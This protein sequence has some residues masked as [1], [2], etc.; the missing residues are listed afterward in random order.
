MQ[1]L[2]AGEVESVLEAYHSGVSSLPAE[3]RPWAA[4]NVTEPDPSDLARRLDDGFVGAC[5]PADALSGPAGFDRL[6]GVLE[7]LE[8]REL[9]LFIHPGPPALP[10]VPGAPSWWSAM[11]S[12]VASMQAAWYAMAVWGRSAHPRLRVC[13]A[14]LA[15]LAPLHRERLAARGGYPATADP[16]LFLDTSSYGTRAVDAVARELG[17]ERLVHGSDRPVVAATEPELGDAVRTSLRSRN[18]QALLST[19]DLNTGVCA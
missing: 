1:S 8:R 16:G 10:A 7:M 12:Y 15:G 6:G 14:M 19:T 11:T 2:P 17:V 18:P 5:I 9:P 4:V 13:F 3:F